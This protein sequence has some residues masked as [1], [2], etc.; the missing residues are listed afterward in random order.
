MSL[1][2]GTWSF[3]GLQNILGGE[4]TDVRGASPSVCTLWIAPQDQI[5]LSPG[6]L[7]L[8]FGNTV[9]NFPGFAMQKA[10]LRKWHDGG[11]QIWSLQ[12]LDRRWKW[13]LGTISGEWNRR[14]PD[15]SVDTAT[16]KSPAELAGLLLDAMGES[17]YNTSA[18][19]SGMW[20]YANWRATNPAN[21]LARLC[22]SVGCDIVCGETVKIV[23]V[24]QGL[25]LPVGRHPFYRYRPI[26]RPT[27][28]VLQ[29]GRNLY[30]TKLK[31]EPIAYE[32]SWEQKR[33]NDVT[34][35]PTA[36]WNREHPL[37]F[38]GLTGNNLT[39]AKSSIYKVF[40]V[41][42][43]QNGGLSVP[44][45]TG[46][47]EKVT[48]YVL[49]DTQ[50]TTAEDLDD[51]KRAAPAYIDGTFWNYSDDPTDS[52][53]QRYYGQWKLDKEALLVEFPQPMF[54]LDSSYLVEDPTLYLNT[55]YSLKDKDGK[56]V[57]Y[58][59]SRNIGG[60]GGSL[61]VRRPEVF[62]TIA[63]GTSTADQ[64]DQEA[65]A[66]LGAIAGRYESQWSYEMEYPGWLTGSLDGKIE[67]VRYC[68]TVNRPATTHVSVMGE[69][70]AMTPSARERRDR[71]IAAQL[72]EALQ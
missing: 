49:R 45:Y 64:A 19:P 34:Y 17:G 70:D 46:Q 55:S 3:P 50:I 1:P 21:A 9:L 6:T 69:F 47:I 37:I 59:K 72:A 39:A 53:S 15:G 61:V 65:E 58:S 27:T 42:E 29:G 20:P 26:S 38:D 16:K 25:E 22:E 68:G 12:L 60:S 31:L 36:G 41:K 63:N 40:R 56:D 28:L 54:G 10:Y 66:Y 13:S 2:A 44:G 67:Q 18:M 51:Y 48:Q 43:Q 7:T 71:Q 4:F 57:L 11:R 30:Q 23:R 62:A 32:T 35:K 5:D 14:L 8:T 24:G 33:L 52:E